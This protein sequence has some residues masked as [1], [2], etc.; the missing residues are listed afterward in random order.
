MGSNDLSAVLERKDKLKRHEHT[1]LTHA[2]EVDDAIA[3]AG[4]VPITLLGTIWP[5]KD[6]SVT[7]G[8]S[9]AE[10]FGTLKRRAVPD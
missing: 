3:S 8:Q 5:G 4:S 10:E 2:F 6:I 1:R 7:R 9:S